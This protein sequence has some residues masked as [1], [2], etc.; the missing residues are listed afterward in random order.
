[1]TIF[2]W[3]EQEVN[4]YVTQNKLTIRSVI[5]FVLK[6][7]DFKFF[8]LSLQALVPVDDDEKNSSDSD[9]SEDSSDDDDGSD[10]QPDDDHFLDS[11]DD[12]KPAPTA[13]KG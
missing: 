6:N 9:S 11:D 5:M 2:R 4:I 1:M 8:D 10:S 12:V 13:S 3:I 7:V